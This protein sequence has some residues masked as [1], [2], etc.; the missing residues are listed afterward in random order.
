MAN[1]IASYFITINTI[2][3]TLRS[4]SDRSES[5]II[6]PCLITICTVQGASKAYSQ[7]GS[8]SSASRNRSYYP[9]VRQTRDPLSW[10][11]QPLQLPNPVWH[12]LPQYASVVPLI[13][14]SLMFLVAIRV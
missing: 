3:T 13:P 14:I 2:Y 7:V 8:C 10:I 4:Q 12:P 1:L 5:Y 9:C 11:Q 6:D